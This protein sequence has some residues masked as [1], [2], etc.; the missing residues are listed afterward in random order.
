M[1]VD[2]QVLQKILENW[3]HSFSK[4]KV[5]DVIFQSKGSNPKPRHKHISPLTYPEKEVTVESWAK[6][7]HFQIMKIKYIAG[8]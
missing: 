4:Q 8:E 6:Q 7:R 5:V 1:A 3:I 2:D